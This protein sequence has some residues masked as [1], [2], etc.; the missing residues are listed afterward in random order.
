MD[1][2]VAERL[3]TALAPILGVAR[4]PVRLQA[5]DGTV[6]GPEDAP[7]VVLRSPQAVRR[8]VWA[9]GELVKLAAVGS[10]RVL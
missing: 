8:L 4:L 1:A 9:H 6:A 5:W 2:T 7:L 10:M 3:A